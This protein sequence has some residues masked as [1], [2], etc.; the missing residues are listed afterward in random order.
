MELLERREGESDELWY[1]RKM[2][3]IRKNTTVGK[4][5]DVS[6]GQKG[7]YKAR[8]IK[9]VLDTYMPFLNAQGIDVV[10]TDIQCVHA[11]ET[12]FKGIYTYKF[13]D[14]HTGFSEEVKTVG[15]GADRSDKDTGKATT[16]AFK[17]LFTTRFSA[18]SGEDTDQDGT[19]VTI[20]DVL[21]SIRATMKSLWSAGYFM[22]EI[23]NPGKSEKQAEIQYQAM[24]QEIAK[25]INNGPWLMK[26]EKEL[27]SEFDSFT[28]R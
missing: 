14:I 28:K 1:R 24:G 3:E 6:M 12:N 13:T 17:Y 23:I 11:S 16:Y 2:L 4:D 8:S 5:M 7:S 19:D 21:G 20:D 25:H 18:D 10:C 22:N 26:K 15:G 27:K 9:A